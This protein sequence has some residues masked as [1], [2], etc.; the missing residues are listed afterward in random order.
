MPAAAVAELQRI[1]STTT[2]PD[3]LEAIAVLL[4]QQGYLIAAATVRAHAAAL[5]ARGA[6]GVVQKI[7]TVIATPPGAA[8]PPAP[9]S[10]AYKI[11]NTT[12]VP[13]ILA[14]RYTGDANR[15]REILP[16]NPNMVVKQVKNKDGKVTTL[17][18]PWYVG[19][20]VNLPGPWL[21]QAMASRV[22]A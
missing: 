20:V 2:D 18:E 8:P 22:A 4:E 14:K 11:K 15:W 1:L 13:Y 3:R 10:F 16:L 17:V 19:L 6:G 21:A 7:E 5:R 12:E 9:A